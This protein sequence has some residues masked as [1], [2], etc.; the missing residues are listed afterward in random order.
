MALMHTVNRN[1]I[2]H[3]LS[4]LSACR[5]HVGYPPSF[6]PRIKGTNIALLL[7]LAEAYLFVLSVESDLKSDS[8]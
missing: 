8:V 5:L 3:K 2:S 6:K 7:I 1:K 4:R